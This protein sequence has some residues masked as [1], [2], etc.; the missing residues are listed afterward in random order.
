MQAYMESIATQHEEFQLSSAGLFV[1]IDMP[2]IG[3]SP[4]GIIECKCH[5]KG[6]LEV[7][8][9][10][11]Y[12]DKLPDEDQANF[13]MNQEEGKWRL[14]REHTYYFQVQTQLHV[15]KVVYGDFVV[16]SENGMLIERIEKDTTFLDTWKESI[17]HFFIYGILPEIVGKWY[18]RKPCADADG[19]V[20]LPVNSDQPDCQQSQEDDSSTL[21]C[22]CS[23]PEFGN[24]IKC[25]NRSC[26]IQ[27]FHFDCLEMRAAPKGK[28]YCPSCVKLPKFNK[29]KRK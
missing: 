21:W 16:W 23:K 18:T 10:F 6:A 25:D 15:C 7:K 17:K 11:C 19:V 20:S 29:S 3:A 27:W 8:C 5:G 9:P 24:M 13:C 1:D 4:D 12:K 22:Y 26:T 28:W 2:Y 14:K